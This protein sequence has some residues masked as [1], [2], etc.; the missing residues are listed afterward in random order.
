MRHIDKKTYANFLL[1]TAIII[2]I[3]RDYVW[4]WA[5]YKDYND[6]LALTN[7][8]GFGPNGQWFGQQVYST[9]AM[10]A[11]SLLLIA[12]AYGWNK[13]GEENQTTISDTNAVLAT[14]INITDSELPLVNSNRNL[15]QLDMRDYSLWVG[16][17]LAGATFAV[18]TWNRGQTQGINLFTNAGLSPADAGYLASLLTG[19]YEGPT[20]FIFINLVRLLS[21]EVRKETEENP[22][23]YLQLKAK[24]GA[25][26]IVPGLIPGG[27]WQVVYNA[28]SINNWGAQPTSA[29]VAAVVAAANAAVAKFNDA[30]IASRC[31]SN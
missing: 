9:A 15:M 21:A 18:Y 23:K 27:L 19:G 10:A 25:L 13:C 7:N 24:E 29:A 3:V 8:T 14:P 16:A 2:N 17:F 5:S 31:C 6:R 12:G 28:G 1:F 20:Q 11:T 26:S 30:I 22:K 4:T